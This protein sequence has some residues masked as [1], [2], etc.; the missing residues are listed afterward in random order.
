MRPQTLARRAILAAFAKYGSPLTAA[1]IDAERIAAC[2]TKN[3]I[4]DERSELRSRGVLTF[5]HDGN[6]HEVGTGRPLWKRRSRR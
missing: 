2:V 1:Q 6:G 3:A 5:S 4:D